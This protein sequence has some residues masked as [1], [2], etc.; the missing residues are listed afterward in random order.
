MFLEGGV[1]HGF[2]FL[3]YSWLWFFL[4][5][6]AI[7]MHGWAGFYIFIGCRFPWALFYTTFL[8]FYLL[9]KGSWC[10][11]LWTFPFSQLLLFHKLCGLNPC[12]CF[13]MV[14][15]QNLLS[16][17]WCMSIHMSSHATTRTE[18]LCIDTMFFCFI[19][20][21]GAD[22]MIYSWMLISGWA[23]VDFILLRIWFVLQRVQDRWNV[24]GF[25]YIRTS[26]FIFHSSVFLRLVL[27]TLCLAR[28]PRT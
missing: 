9:C 4:K 24:S 5:F 15:L 28:F 27:C 23:K 20:L 3:W 7:E 26:F 17:N 18:L 13:L 21:F 6:S 16:A 14:T 1:I 10:E 11:V 2:F 19:T 25:M 22:T 12:L 8:S